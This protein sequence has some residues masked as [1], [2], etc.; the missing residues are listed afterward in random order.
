MYERSC[1]YSAELW[2][3]GEYESTPLGGDL[4][5][6]EDEVKDILKG[7]PGAEEIQKVVKEARLPF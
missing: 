6:T 5:A 4:D 2:H 1:T 3:G 7:S